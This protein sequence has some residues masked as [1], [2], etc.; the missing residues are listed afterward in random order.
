MS[1]NVAYIGC[2]ES[3]FDL[4]K[5]IHRNHISISEIVTLTPE[6]GKKYSV[7]GYYDHSDFARQ[8]GIPVYTPDTYKMDNQRDLE[9][10]RKLDT[11]VLIV[12][13]WQ[14][15]IPKEILDTFSHGAFGLHGSAF[16][17]PKGRGRSPM[18]WSLIE[19]L[20]RFVLSILRL[21]SGVDSG[22]VVDSKK[23]GINQHDDIQTMY[24]KLIMAAQE[25]YNR[26]LDDILAGNIEVENQEGEPTYYPKRTPD[27]GAIH[28]QDPTHVIYNLVRAVA[29]PYPGA[30]TEYDSTRIAIHDAQPFSSDFIPEG[31]PGQIVNV[32]TPTQ[33][34][35]VKTCDGTLLVTDWEADGWTPKVGMQFISLS[36][37]SIGSPNRADSRE[38]EN[39]LSDN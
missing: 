33:D 36:N 2:T 1:M 7:A 39:L 34:F 4:M 38:K 10:F 9:H 35:V 31:E 14:R 24:Y 18:N 16:D 28:W 37:E 12:H 3:G 23:F 30:F 19:N 8:E 22:E 15:L 32:F 13:G 27:D 17:L 21:D 25:M 29:P 26:T 6:Q 11:D 20:E 5:Y